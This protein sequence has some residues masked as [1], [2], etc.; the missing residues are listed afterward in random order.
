MIRVDESWQD[1]IE[2]AYDGL[3]SE[4]REFLENNRGYFP[5]YENFLNAF[6]TLK[7]ENTKYILFGQ[8]PYP[9]EKSAI[10]YAFI[11]G[12]VKEIFS[13]TGLSKEVNRA[14]SLRNF[15]KML[16][17][18]EGVLKED[19]LR[20]E[21][22]AKLDK[23]NYINSIDELRVNFEKNGVLLLNTA[24]I[25]TDKK[26]T[27][28]HVKKFRVFIQRVLSRLDRN[29]IEL[30]L[31]GNMAKDIKKQIPISLEFKSFET[32]HPYNVGFIYESKVQEFFKPMRLLRTTLI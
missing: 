2:Y 11:D 1:I 29:K 7:L 3:D 17:L 13:K 12:N 28:L 16:L 9:R 31:F 19:N 24:L 27:K 4:Y 32:L 18:C 22:I 25:F 8:D 6:H 26:D 14:T 21:A 15:I 20:Q 23:T 30:I 10:G 5:T